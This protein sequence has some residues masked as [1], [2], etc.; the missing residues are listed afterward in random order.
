M[1][2]SLPFSACGFGGEGSSLRKNGSS[3]S[4][5]TQVS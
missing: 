3:G 4:L 5:L 2:R 1:A